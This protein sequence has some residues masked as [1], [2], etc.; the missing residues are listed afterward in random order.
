MKEEGYLIIDRAIRE[1]ELTDYEAG[2]LI[3]SLMDRYNFIGVVYGRP[4]ATEAWLDYTDEDMT[5]EEWAKMQ[6]TYYWKYGMDR[7]LSEAGNE[8]LL[9]AIRE[10]QARLSKEVDQ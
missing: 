4:E 8:Q 7:F 5:D 3:Q 1:N 6:Q 10:V 2:W 9:G